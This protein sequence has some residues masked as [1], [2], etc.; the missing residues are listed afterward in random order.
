MPQTFSS[1]C[2]AWMSTTSNSNRQDDKMNDQP[3]LPTVSMANT[4][5]ELL[6]AYEEAKKRFDSL[7][8]DLLDAEKARKRM[9]K[10]L[11]TATADAQAAQDPVARL[12]ELRGAISRELGDLAERFEKEIETYRKVQTAIETKQAELTTIYEV[13]TAASDLAALIDAQRIKKEQFEQEMTAKKTAFESE[14]E[15][16]RAHWQREKADHE[17]Q[18]KEQAEALKIQRQREKEEYEYTFARE[19]EQRKN[20]LA[21]ELQALEKD[22]ALRRSRFESDVQQRTAALDAREEAIAARE[23]EMANLQKEVESFPKRTE[24]AVQ[25][26]VAETTKRLSRDFES[27]KALIQAR[28]DGEKN[29]LVGKIEALEKMAAS[30]AALI[31]DLSKKSELAYEK[32]QDIANRAVTAA[33]RESYVPP[34]Q[35]AGV[36]VRD[37]K[38]G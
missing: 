6:D 14:I 27:D 2:A 36:A 13:E 4:K 10:Q 21:D 19:K 20:A 31:A 1:G 22:I 8:K 7:S 35:H 26:A 5:K 29:V 16:L 30:Q 15:G 18:V 24:S 17:R 11:A 33:R 25:A 34:V 28:F 3:D 32:V 12:H 9:E 38:Q 37:D 23:K